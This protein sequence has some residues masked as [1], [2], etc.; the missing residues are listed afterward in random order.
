MADMLK[1]IL[2]DD[3]EIVRQGL[4]AL[5]EAE[6]DIEVVEEAES[7]EAVDMARIHRPGVIVMDVRMPDINGVEAC[8]E[9][10]DE[11]SRSR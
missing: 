8:R 10:R 7:G 4:R 11:R 1:V 9:I 3:H 5:L 6:E 2:V